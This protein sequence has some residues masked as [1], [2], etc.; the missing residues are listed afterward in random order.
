MK[1][2]ELQIINDKV[3]SLAEKEQKHFY[4]GRFIPFTRFIFVGEM[5]TDP[6]EWNPYDNFNLSISDK[7]FFDLLSKYGFGGSYITD[8]VKKTE[9]PRRP[10]EQE[11]SE[12]LPILTEEISRINPD[13]TVAISKDTFETL[14]KNKDILGISNLECIWHPSYVQRYNKWTE[15]ENQIKLL[16]KR[17]NSGN[18]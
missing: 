16:S 17:Y 15:Y 11:L 4:Y 2:K 5:P 14:N 1:L 6:K 7:K 10:T 18:D 13:V 9:D 12:W 3:R 8:I